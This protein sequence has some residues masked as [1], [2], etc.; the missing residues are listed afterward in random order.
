MPVKL[1][2]NM[3]TDLVKWRGS[4]G[5]FGNIMLQQGNM[6]YSTNYLYFFPKTIIYYQSPI[7]K[8]AKQDY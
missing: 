2:R 6:K 8:P 3:V 1:P 7:L 4:L 5:Y